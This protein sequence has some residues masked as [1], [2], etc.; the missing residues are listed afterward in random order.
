MSKMRSDMATVRGHRACLLILVALVI[1][2]CGSSLRNVPYSNHFNTPTVEHDRLE[3]RP[4]AFVAVHGWTSNPG[5]AYREGDAPWNSPGLRSSLERLLESRNE[6]E[7]WDIWGVDWREGAAV[8]EAAMGS[9]MPCTQNEINAQVQGQWIAK[10]LAEQNQYEHVHLLGHSLGGRVIESASTMIRQVMP[11]AT[12]HTTFLDAYSPYT[13]DHVYGSTAD[14]ADHYHNANDWLVRMT[15]EAFPSALNVDISAIAPP[16]NSNWEHG[17][18]SWGH[19]APVFFYRD[20]MLDPEL[21]RYYGYGMALSR[22]VLG[23]AWPAAGEP[24]ARNQVVTLVQGAD[25]QRRE[26]PAHVVREGSEFTA[27]ISADDLEDVRGTVDTGESR[28][29]LS[30]TEESSIAI[31]IFQFETPAEANFL[32][33]DF[34]WSNT[35]GEGRLVFYVDDEALWGTETRVG[36]DRW[37]S[38]GK[39]MWT[40]MLARIPI[41]TS[42][43]PGTH[44]IAFRL[45]R[46]DGSSVAIQVRNVRGGMLAPPAQ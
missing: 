6:A 43:D 1:T 2:G 19:N 22:E 28:T 42:L 13:W 12:I 7:D 32:E 46:L 15:N 18:Q 8:C 45:E 14:F 11:G 27:R 9:A 35:S 20:T 25:P 17:R 37:L 40:G 10:V 36:F 3:G 23:E 21:G 24:F 39:V 41:E 29:Q 33:F 5:V 4:N 44:E 16:Y 30:G 31:A 38:T 34:L 26:E